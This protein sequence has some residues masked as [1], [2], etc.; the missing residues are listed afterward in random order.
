MNVRDTLITA[1]TPLGYEVKLQGSYA[2]DAP[3]PESFITYTVVDAPDGS[4]YDGKPTLT[5]HRIQ[6]VFYSKKMSL[7]NTVPDLIYQALKTAGF[8][9]DGKGRD[10]GYEVEHYGLLVNYLFTERNE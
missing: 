10:Y 8:E 1:L 7:I 9:R 6:I 5:H 4:F 3:L 2:D